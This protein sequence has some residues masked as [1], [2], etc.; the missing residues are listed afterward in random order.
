MIGD[1]AV[2]DPVISTGH[3]LE[4]RWCVDAKFNRPKGM[5]SPS[6]A[7]HAKWDE[8]RFKVDEHVDA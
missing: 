7:W 1:A 2:A 5:S 3:L 8:L 4:A 6:R